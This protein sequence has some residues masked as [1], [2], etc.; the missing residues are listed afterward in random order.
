MQTSESNLE[1]PNLEKNISE[2]SLI[3]GDTLD[4]DFKD[5]MLVDSLKLNDSK[6]TEKNTI[7]ARRELNK[8]KLE[9]LKIKDSNLRSSPLDR[10]INK[11]ASAP[12]KKVIEKPTRST[13]NFSTKKIENIENSVHQI[14]MSMDPPVKSQEGKS[15]LTQESNSHDLDRSWEEIKSIIASGLDSKIFS[16]WFKPLKLNQIITIKSSGLENKDSL[17]LK[18]LTP[19]KFFSEHIK[20]NYEAL[21][22]SAASSVLSCSNIS[23][24]YDVCD[25]RVVPKSNQNTKALK[26]S[27]QENSKLEISS[28]SNIRPNQNRISNDSQTNLSLNY[29]F[30]NFVVGTC[31]QFAHAACSKVAESPGNAY[32]PLLIYG[33]VGL[34]KTHLANAIG[35][36]AKRRKKKVLLV[37]SEMFVTELIGSLKN[38]SMERFKSKFRSLDVLIIDDIQFIIGK[39]RTQEEFFHTFNELYGKNKQIIITSDKLPQD[40]IGLEERLRT[41]FQSGLSVDLQAPDFET[42]VAILSNKCEQ[43]DLKISDDI[44]KLIAM[45]IDTNVRELE[46]ALTRLQALCNLLGEKPSLQLAQKVLDTISPL[47]SRE[48]TTDYI[49]EVVAKE[50]N[51]SVHDLSGKRRTQN[52]ALARQVAMF[53]C[54]KHTARSFPEIGALFG[55]RDHSTV[56]HA[57][58][59]ITDRMPNEESLRGQIEKIVVKLEG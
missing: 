48:L 24:E 3:Q 40:L 23:L 1:R 7:K 49:K 57:I 17:L 35:N 28:S 53:L 55:G 54:R 21:I 42:R 51:V 13:T 52:I 10:T 59:S 36:A 47:K 30:S 15:D 22:K 39:E 37:S 41:R 18:I 29:N 11:I 19:N 38:N 45:R 16:A 20:K 43:S 50:F 58:K 14:L 44:L 9:S 33:G 2:A 12:N 56:I 31:N 46:G 27:S 6:P 5:A 8:L 32:N 34:G 26:L 25:E 4:Q